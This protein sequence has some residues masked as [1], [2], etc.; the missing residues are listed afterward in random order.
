MTVG[1]DPVGGQALHRRPTGTARPA[2][3]RRLGNSVSVGL[4]DFS[5]APIVE[6]SGVVRSHL[7]ALSRVESSGSR[8]VAASLTLGVASLA[9]YWVAAFLGGL[10]GGRHWAVGLVHPGPGLAS[11]WYRGRYHGVHGKTPDE[12][13]RP[14]KKRSSRGWDSDGFHS[15]WCV[16]V[17]SRTPHVGGDPDPLALTGQRTHKSG[18]RQ[19]C[20]GYQSPRQGGPRRSRPAH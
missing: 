17:V 4:N 9:W 16:L 1:P 19:S 11:H 20:D 2:G 13:L 6:P 5:E 7:P 8:E 10:T 14:D 12:T 15:H 3:R 18:L